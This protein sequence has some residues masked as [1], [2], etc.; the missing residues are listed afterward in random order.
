MLDKMLIKTIS[1]NLMIVNF[2]VMRL[3]NVVEYLTT[4]MHDVENIMFYCDIFTHNHL[5]PFNSKDSIE[6]WDKF[7][8]TYKN[9]SYEDMKNVI[10]IAIENSKPNIKTIAIVETPG[11]FHENL[12]HCEKLS[13][14]S[15]S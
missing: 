8:I 4:I 1:P 3:S 10:N 2:S 13:N 6:G 5:L 14:S 9:I 7:K 15:F 11:V 12:L